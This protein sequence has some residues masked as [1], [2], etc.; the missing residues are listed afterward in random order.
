M[1]FDFKM[2]NC[3]HYHQEE[4]GKQGLTNTKSVSAKVY[5]LAWIKYYIAWPGCG[6]SE[7]KSLDDF[8]KANIIKGFYREEKSDKERGV[9]PLEKHSLMCKAGGS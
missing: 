4:L 5:R 7:I 3:L 8:V 2:V 6:D 9:K 1:P